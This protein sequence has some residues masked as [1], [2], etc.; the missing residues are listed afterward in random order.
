MSVT[1]N[2]LLD[3][4]CA[5]CGS[6]DVRFV[7][8]GLAGPTDEMDQFVDCA[9][10]GRVTYDFVTRTTRDLRFG[11]YR[12]GGIFRDSVHQTRYEITRILKIGAREHLIYLKPLPIADPTTGP[13]RSSDDGP[14]VAKT[15]D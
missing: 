12:P 7:Q 15:P 5:W 6:A 9:A 2:P 8:R 11:R 10:C 13:R 1:H 4:T 14:S 3:R